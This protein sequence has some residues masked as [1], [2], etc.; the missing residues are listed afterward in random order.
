MTI[1]FPLIRHATAHLVSAALLTGCTLAA[2]EVEP[3][4][5]A[6]PV[7]QASTV[8]YR[9]N[10][11]AVV[12]HNYTDLF[13][14]IVFPFLGPFA[15]GPPVQGQLRA[16]SLLTVSSTDAQNVVR[17]GYVQH[18]LAWQLPHFRG[19][20]TYRL[21]PGAAVL[22]LRTRDA[23]DETWLPGPAQSLD[24]R[25]EAEIVVTDWNP[26]TRH[27]RGTFSL[28]FDAAGNAPAAN[29][30]DGVFDLVVVP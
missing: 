1:T 22:Q 23:A 30:R 14:A 20:R 15:P 24:P 13:S 21:P 27:L 9:L 4:L 11:R 8:T 16:D 18:S 3:E 28:L 12:A 6:A 2:T 5:P 10:G 17:P 25:G 26:A 7:N 29:V 19:V